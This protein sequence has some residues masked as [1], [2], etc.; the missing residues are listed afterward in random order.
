[1]HI[2]FNFENIAN[3]QF[4]CFSVIIKINNL[5]FGKYWD[6]Y[7]QV[8]MNEHDDVGLCNSTIERRTWLDLQTIW[9]TMDDEEE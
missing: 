3:P 1:M 6:G 9:W 8:P 5:I 7:E 2:N 4:D